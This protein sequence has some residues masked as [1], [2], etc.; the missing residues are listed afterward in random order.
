VKRIPHV[1]ERPVRGVLSCRADELF[2]WAAGGPEPEWHDC[3]EED[4]LR[5]AASRTRHCEYSRRLRA[6][7][8]RGGR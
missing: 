5:R 1:T 8:R 3:A 4:R 2:A 7:R 6:R